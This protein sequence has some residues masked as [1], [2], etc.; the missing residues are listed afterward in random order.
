MKNAVGRALPQYVEGYGS[1][2]PYQGPFC[3]IPE[4]NRAAPKVK[5]A[6][7]HQ[8]KVVEKQFPSPMG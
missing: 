8:S 2:R 5:F 6:K 7:P 1:V 4:M 3:T